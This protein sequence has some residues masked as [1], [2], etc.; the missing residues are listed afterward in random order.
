MF[1]PDW[2]KTNAYRILNVP[3]GVSLSEIHKAATSMRRAV[4]LGAAS[5]T[6]ADIPVL[7]EIPRTEA[8]IRV[9]TGRLENPTQRIF[10]RFFWL[11]SI[12]SAMSVRPGG[13]DTALWNHDQALRA[14]FA[15]FETGFDEAGIRSEERRVGK[16]CR[17]R[18]S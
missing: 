12:D 5:A 17:S 6:E 15:A 8:D 16:E 18:W 4:L 9:A 3:A 13:L 7:G 11:H 14:I 2:L 1:V 10:D